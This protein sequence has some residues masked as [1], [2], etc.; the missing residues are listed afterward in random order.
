MARCRL[1]LG[2]L[3]ALGL[4]GVLGLFA[5][6]APPLAAA[7][8]PRSAPEAQ[9]V[10]SDD[11]LAF[12]E[13]LDAAG[14]P[15]VAD[16]IHSVVLVRHGVVIAEGW[17][18]PYGPELRHQLYSLSKSFTSTG[19]GIAAAEGK[20]HVDD[21]VLKFFPTEAPAAPAAVGT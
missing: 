18:A 11:L 4:V 10:S 3:G 13:A 14:D 7:E 2:F 8:L 12:V 1:L 21:P 6:P 20:L 5:A 15:A 17:W 16:G 9:G 19:V